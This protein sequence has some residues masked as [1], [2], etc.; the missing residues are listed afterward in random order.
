LPITIAIH[1]TSPTDPTVLALF[2]Q[3]A[4]R[5]QNLHL[6]CPPEGWINAL[7][8]MNNP[9]G[10]LSIDAPEGSWNDLQ[11]DA[12]CS[13]LIL[14]SFTRVRLR[15]WENI[16]VLHLFAM[17]D[18][19]CFGLLKECINLV[20]YRHRQKV[21]N[22]DNRVNVDGPFTLPHLKVFEW[23]FRVGAAV[24]DAI[25]RNLRMPVLETLI[26]EERGRNIRRDNLS[27]PTNTFFACLPHS[28]HTLQLGSDRDSSMLF[29][30][31]NNLVHN[32]APNVE[33]LIIANFQETT[34]K[35][36]RLDRLFTITGGEFDDHQRYVLPGLRVITLRVYANVNPGMSPMRLRT[37]VIHLGGDGFDALLDMVE[38]WVLH[39]ARTNPGQPMRLEI[40]VHENCSVAWAAASRKGLKKLVQ[41]GLELEVIGDSALI[42]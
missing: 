24:D 38:S 2:M 5:I 10:F 12:S 34:F 21:F 13:H 7:S 4:H 18:K 9:L 8:A 3:H 39:R 16:T 25:L 19:V 30:S 14:R 33:H 17:E 20:E 29:P 32:N 27:D 36:N 31:V 28:L 37:P 42:G 22:W 6:S 1:F 35:L 15:C 26:W 23:P 40:Q 11:V 41:Q